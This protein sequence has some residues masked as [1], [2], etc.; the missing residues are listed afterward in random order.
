MRRVVA[1]AVVPTGRGVD[2]HAE[3]AHRRPQ[4]AHGV[5]LRLGVGQRRLAGRPHANAP[6]PD[7]ADAAADR[8]LV[9]PAVRG[10]LLQRAH[11]RRRRGPRP[12]P[13]PRRLHL[14]AQP[15]R[16]RAPCA[17]TAS[18]RRTCAR[19]AASTATY[20]RDE[21][22]RELHR[23][24]PAVHIWD[25]HEVENNYSDNLPAP[26]PLQR[27]RRLPRRL[28]VDPAGR[29]PARPLPHLQADRAR[30]D[31]RPVPARRAP[32][33]DRRRRRAAAQHPRRRADAVADRRAARPRRA[34][35][36]MIAQQ[37][38]VA[39]NP[40][41]TGEALDAWDGYPADRTLLLGEIERLGIA[42]VVFLTGDAHVFACSLLASDF[43]ALGDGTARPSA[44]EY[45]GGSVTSP[46]SR[47]ARGGR[48]RRVAVDPPVQRARPRLRA[49]RARQRA[50]RDGVPPQRPQ[51]PVR[52]HAGVRALHPAGGRQRHR[53]PG[54]GAAGLTK[55]SRCV[56]RIARLGRDRG[57]KA[58]LGTHALARC[59][60][61]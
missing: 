50:T 45:I 9:L 22:L 30:R 11:P 41:G 59:P 17:S 51:L 55:R 44:V 18:T 40:Y 35:W 5:L 48:P 12:V 43:T 52:R 1:T 24:H 46:G 33:P 13:L 42:N 58:T 61:R 56:S 39:A 19:T 4:A 8:L 27:D 34:R 14:R 21:G 20:R 6:P 54:A 38:S 25:D 28:R 53:A 10:R 23:L 47:H 31:R 15:A 3:D 2:Q 49:R 26:A 7:S 32:V 36:K 57:M 60:F 16:R 37:V 29:R